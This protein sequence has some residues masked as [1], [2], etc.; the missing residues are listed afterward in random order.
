MFEVVGEIQQRVDEDLVA[1]HAF[2]GIG[3]AIAGRRQLFAHKTA[4][5][6]VRH[7]HR[8][9]HHLR[10]HQAQHFGAEVF[11]AVRPA[12]A[13]ARHFGAAQMRAFHARAVNPDFKQ[14]VRLG[15]KIDLRRADF[16]AD[17]LLGLA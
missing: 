4:F 13:A 15:Q 3:F 16:E 17:V 8:V 1:G 11:H 9:F 7:N 6:A 14:G 12:Q 2:G 5:G 10:F